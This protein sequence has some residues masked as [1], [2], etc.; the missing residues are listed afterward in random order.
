MTSR[1]KVWKYV[2]LGTLWAVALS[3]SL[4]SEPVFAAIVGQ[5][6]SICGRWGCAAPLATLLQWHAAVATVLFPL[7]W[8]SRNWSWLT[9]RHRSW[10]L[11]LIVAVSIC[12]YVFADAVIWV[13]PNVDRNFP[14]IMNRALYTAISQTDIPCLPLLAASVL[15]WQRCRGHDVPELSTDTVSAAPLESHVLVE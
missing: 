5:G 15:T 1:Q 8:Q 4:N 3:G 12:L 11:M 6:H 13:L 2:G 7:A 10:S 14:N 9:V